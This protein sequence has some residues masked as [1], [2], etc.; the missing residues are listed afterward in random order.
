VT[1]ALALALLV[2]G[3][4]LI[5]AVVRPPHMPE[6][7][8]ASVGAVLLVIVGAIGLSGAGDALR[9]LGPTVG[10]LAAMLLIADGCRREGLFDAMG[11]IMAR[12]SAGSPQRLLAFV[13][14][15][16]AV[17]TA[18]LSLDA[19]IVLLTEAQRRLGRAATL[20]T[21]RGRIEREVV[22]AAEHIDIL[23][24]A[25]DGDRERLGPHSLGPATRFVID[26]APCQVL[27]I[28]PE[29]TPEL[30]TLPPPPSSQ[31]SG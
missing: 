22:T 16:A 29:S 19:T 14:V 25:R 3:S 21:R 17:I 11:A 23:V 27:I 13:F 15:V 20:E 28:W 4:T 2:L 18:V 5:V 24:L 6:A 7:G 9:A 12:G 10:F 1:D 30:A 31:A 8:V 26:H